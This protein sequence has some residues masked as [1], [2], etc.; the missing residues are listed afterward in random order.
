MLLLLLFGYLSQFNLWG[1]L[2]QLSLR[3]NLGLF[4]HFGRYCRFIM[5]VK[6]MGYLRVNTTGFALT[7]DGLGQDLLLSL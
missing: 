1:L 4:L 5:S 7:V 2:D 6:G 3:I